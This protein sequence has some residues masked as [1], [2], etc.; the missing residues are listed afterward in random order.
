M[1]LQPFVIQ[2]KF[3]HKLVRY[4][5]FFTGIMLSL[6]FSGSDKNLI[7]AMNNNSSN[8]H[9]VIVF[10]QLTKIFADNQDKKIKQVQRQ[11]DVDDINSA[12]LALLPQLTF[13][14]KNKI[15]WKILALYYQA[16][17]KEAFGLPQGS[18][19]RIKNEITMEKILPILAHSPILSVNQAQALA[20]DAL[21]HNEPKTTLMFY[22]RILSTGVY[23]AVH[24]Y[25]NVAT[26]A[27]FVGD[28]PK[29][30]KYFFLAMQKSN[31]IDQKRIYF[32]DAVNALTADGKPE[33]SLQVAIKNIDGLNNDKQTLLFLSR[34]A[35]SSN[36]VD[37]AEKYITQVIQ[38]HF[39]KGW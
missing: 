11:I 23:R 39:Q 6:F 16:I 31:T 21:A 22:D 19:L 29:S 3:R 27:F 38:L 14:P 20:E 12:K 8:P 30:A 26:I 15:Q 25:V 5:V 1:S 2:R 33:K 24:F 34:L 7:H 9:V 17:R 36:N 32:V 28:Y 35:L 4:I 18:G 37:L 13:S 10:P